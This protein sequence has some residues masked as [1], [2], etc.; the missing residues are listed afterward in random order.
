MVRADLEHAVNQVT[1]WRTTTIYALTHTDLSINLISYF[2]FRTRQA[3]RGIRLPIPAA[4]A[5]QRASTTSS[6]TDLKKINHPISHLSVDELRNDKCNMHI[7]PLVSVTFSLCG[8]LL[9]APMSNTTSNGCDISNET[10]QQLRAQLIPLEFEPLESDEEHGDAISI[11]KVNCD[12]RPE[13]A[14]SESSVF[15]LRA[16]SADDAL[17]YSNYGTKIAPFIS[18]IRNKA[19][20]CDVV[21]YMSDM[22]MDSEDIKLR[23]SCVDSPPSAMERPWV[24]KLLIFAVFWVTGCTIR[25]V[26]VERRARG[27]SKQAVSRP[28]MSMSEKASVVSV[29]DVEDEFDDS[30]YPM[31]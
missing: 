13:T 4:N 21:E 26:W 8:Q 29:E 20:R 5:T 12:S 17:R 25:K 10:I 2:Q 19:V 7:L 24:P 30:D 23:C 28:K 9:A 1:P 16:S 6:T 11:S 15:C 18:H 22:D 14:P 27:A 3:D 31:G